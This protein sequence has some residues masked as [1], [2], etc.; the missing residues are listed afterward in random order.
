VAVGASVGV[1]VSVGCMVRVGEG[2]DVI[3]IVGVCV[4]VNDAVAVMVV[5]DP[6]GGVEVGL[7]GDVET[8]VFVGVGETSIVL[9]GIS[10]S[11]VA[12]D[13]SLGGKVPPPAMVTGVS[14]GGVRMGSLMVPPPTQLT[15]KFTGSWNTGLE[16]FERS[17]LISLT[18][19]GRTAWISM[20]VHGSYLA[21]RLTWG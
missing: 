4:A 7:L 18:I 1:G 9:L 8:G 19:S 21:A 2:I 13:V 15:F 20:Y 11:V 14:V 16:V 12:E 17:K 3:V 5:V 10:V 6:F